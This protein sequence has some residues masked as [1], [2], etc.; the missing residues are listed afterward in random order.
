MK[1]IILATAIAAAFAAHG[2]TFVP[3][4]S[5]RQM[6]ASPLQHAELCWIENTNGY[7]EA[8]IGGVAGAQLRVTDSAALRGRRVRE[9][10]QSEFGVSADA[11]FT[12]DPA[13]RSYKTTSATTNSIIITVPDIYQVT[14]Y[15]FVGYGTAPDIM[16]ASP[17]YKLDDHGNTAVI[18]VARDECLD[19]TIE[20]IR[21]F[22]SVPGDGDGENDLTTTKFL[23]HDTLGWY[24]F[25]DLRKILLHYYDGNRGANWAA[26][27]ASNH[28]HMAN[29]SIVF[30][31]ASKYTLWS[32]EPASNLTFQAGMMDALKIECTGGVDDG[33]WTYFTITHIDI[34]DP[35]DV[36]LTFAQDI[37]GFDPAALVVAVCEDLS[38][39]IWYGLPGGSY[40]VSGSTVTIPR[41]Q[42]GYK[43][44]FFRLHYRGIATD[45]VRVTISGKVVFPGHV[46]IM[47]EDSKYYRI[48]CTGGVLSAEEVT[49]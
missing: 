23:L 37:S 15:K 45:A 35:E 34:T 38:T 14:E 29:H 43:A 12:Y 26:Y 17:Y 1:R 24:D 16:P 40:T 10:A 5:V 21:V 39:G 8:Y 48:K 11:I 44:R 36:V 41:A 18:H 47:G 27:Q 6:A 28:V 32:S 30:D 22:V 13:K 3:K 33:D 42:V 46:I 4:S 49:L 20:D 7:A 19:C 31:K 25:A 2:T 9:L